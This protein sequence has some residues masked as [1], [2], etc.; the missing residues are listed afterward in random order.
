MAV[1]Y[2]EDPLAHTITLEVDG[3]VTREDFDEISPKFEAFV[4]EHKPI[5]LLEIIH[6]LDGFDA[7]VVWQG[8][9]LDTKVL[10]H[11]SHCAVVGDIGWLS[12]ISKAAGTV[13]STRLRTFPL[14]ELD[15]ARVWIADPDAE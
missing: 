8:I 9:K 14:S 5:R 7:S 4:E 10:P 12:P 13:I 1:T 2:S 15:A 6:K 11:I 3:R